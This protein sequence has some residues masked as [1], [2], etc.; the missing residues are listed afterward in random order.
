MCEKFRILRNTLIYTGIA[1]FSVGIVIG[2][3]VSIFEKDEPK[4]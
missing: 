2:F 1:G 3:I 4:K